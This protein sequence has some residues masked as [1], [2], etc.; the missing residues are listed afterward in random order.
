VLSIVVPTLNAEKELPATL[1]CLSVGGF[2]SEL[3]IA[4][5]GSSDTTPAIAAMHRA[6]FTAALGGRGAQMV[7]GVMYSTGDWLLFLHS[8]T[9][10]QPGWNH[11]AR[12]FIDDPKNRFRAAYFKFILN[13]GAPAAR[14]LERL[15]DW[16]C[17]T[18]G[19]PYGDQGLL[20]S[21]EFYNL[22]GG[23]LPIPLMEDVELV[24]RIGPKRLVQLS[25]AA[26]T[27]AE[28]YRKGGYWLRPARNL[29]CLGLYFAGLPPRL[30]AELYG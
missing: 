2:A 29:L 14:R 16:R 4:D 21:K 18:L 9:R 12:K 28:R 27:S 26:V 1:A 6:K 23:I 25:S 3:I 19:L 24:R 17:K 20:I 7:A 11:I 10:P 15:V 5:G 30:I 8:D 13:D 22:L